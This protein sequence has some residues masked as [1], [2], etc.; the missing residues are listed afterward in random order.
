[1]FN[2]NLQTLRTMML[3]VLAL[4]LMSMMQQARAV[5]FTA[6]I[7]NTNGAITLWFKPNSGVNTTWVNAHYNINGGAQLNVAM[8]KN[9]STGRF[10]YPLTATVGQTVN[11]SFTYDNNGLAYD[12]GWTAGTVPA[13]GGGGGTVAA[14][15]SFS[16]AS[17]TYTTSQ[18]VSVSSSTAGATLLCSINGAAQAVCPNPIL[19]G[20]RNATTTI[21]AIATKSGLSNSAPASASYTISDVLPPYTQGVVDNGSSLTLW[22]SGN[23]ASA[24][25]DAHYNLNGTGQQNIRMNLLNNRQEINLPV[26]SGAAVTLAYS[27]TYMTGTGAMDSTSFS[28]TRGGGGGTGGGTGGTVATPTISPNGGSFSS[29]QSVSL[30]SSTS[31]ASLYYTRDGSTP[32]T[33]STLYSAPFTV[34]SSSTIKAIGVKSGMTNSAVASASFTINSTPTIANGVS[35]D[36]ATAKIWF[37]PSWRPSTA[38]VHYVVTS[39]GGSPTPQHDEAMTFNSTLSRWESVT[40]SPLASGDVISYFF[41]YSQATGGNVDSARFSYTICGDAPASATCPVLVGKP[42]FTPAAGVYTSAQSVSLSLPTSP[43]VVAGTVI[44]Y[45]KDGS[46]PTTASLKYTG[47][48]TV[49]SATTINAIA[50]QPNLTQ[51]RTASAS[52]DIKSACQI[53]NNCPVA[54]PT[55]SHASG[56]YNTVIGVSLLT[57]TPGATVHYTLDG[58]TPTASSAQYYG[59]IWLGN[60]PV[61]GP[62][63]VIKAI[64]VKGGQ[65]SAVE[66]RNYSVTSNNR[67]SWNGFTTFNIVNGTQGKYT[68]DKVYFVIIGKDWVTKQFV[69]AD[70]RGNLLPLSL[71][72]NTIPVPGRD[73]PFADYSITLAQTKSIMLPPI[74]SARV[75]M[76]VGKP[77]LM[78]VNTN[79]LG[80][81][82]Y[83]APALEN[84]TDP[85]LG[86]LFDFAEFN[87]NRASDANPGI[88]INTGRVDFFGFPVQLRVT[89]LDGF[90]ATV[91][92]PLSETRDELFARY[93]LE[94]PSEFKSLALAPYAPNRIIAPAHATFDNGVDV[95][96][97]AQ[98]RT[99]GANA[100]YLDAYITQVW[101]QYKTQDLV[102]NLPGW[103]TFTG[104]IGADNVLTFSDG[105]GSYK[106]R[107]QPT[108]TEVMLGNGV[109]DDATG[110]TIDTPQGK[111]AHDKQLQLQAQMCAALN[112]HVAH[113]TFDKWWNGA[114]FYPAGSLANWYVKF[115]HEHSLNGLSYG[116]SYD[117]VGGFSPS[118]YAPSPV[119]VTYTI[120][121]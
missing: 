70:M 74:E 20:T 98:V 75:Y 96:T 103:P 89:G 68:D 6:N 36:G 50:V 56:T 121:R 105:L 7:D 94:V 82:A 29:S 76:S 72:D 120:G 46:A 61:K 71:A 13:S 107:K 77:V 83:A 22:F 52:Y 53:Q 100:T 32:T 84:P 80:Q 42:L 88:Y 92:E 3:A 101:N 37:A 18:S 5:D 109:L 23:P 108:T 44:Y 62:N 67:S 48:I 85:N 93:S 1:M 65:V 19:V 26:T 73:V 119:T 39:A 90:D 97:G 113:L 81:I 14:T 116:F 115:W 117:D 55:F 38:I 64:A 45:T 91:G 43:A 35:E 58:S 9:S 59:A 40:I 104:R 31:G 63:S 10:E 51:S 60:D 11:F 12:S 66:T 24:W 69:R 17:G 54:S 112:R 111:L 87:I 15:P 33:S 25:V 106:I 28:W 21:S 30:S 8:T 49:S 16:V 41:T 78:Q 110:T 99:R 57:N 4:L 79:I 118:I 27:F 47:P 34:S 95:Q 114:F 86:V 2:R 102:I